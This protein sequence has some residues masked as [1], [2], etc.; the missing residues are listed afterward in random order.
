MQAVAGA[1]ILPPGECPPPTF[2]VAKLSIRPAFFGLLI[3][4]CASAP[5]FAASPPISRQQSVALLDRCSA[6]APRAHPWRA[7]QIRMAS[8]R[9]RLSMSYR[10]AA[11]SMDPQELRSAMAGERESYFLLAETCRPVT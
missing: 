9:L 2:E 4:V 3:A 7:R 11:F 8:L 1:G 5:A 10:A 6:A